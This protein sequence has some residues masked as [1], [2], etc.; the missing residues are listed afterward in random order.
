MQ[1]TVSA[2]VIAANVR[3][4]LEEDI[5]TGD[6]T[7]ML[8]P[9]EQ[10]AK[11]QVITREDATICGVD[12]VNEVF[13]QVD[14]KLEIHWQVKD[15]EQVV[16]NQ[17]LFTCQGPARSLLTAERSALNFLQML[18]GTATSCRQYANQ[19]DGSN[20]KLLD[21]RKTIPGLREAQK[22]AVTCGG[23]HNHRM[24][25][26]DAFLI[27]ENHIMACGGIEQAVLKARE[28]APDK[29][30]E[31][32]VEDLNQLQ[33]AIDAKADVVMLDNFS[34]EDLQAAV[35]INAG[36]AYLE[37]SGNIELESLSKLTNSNVDFISSGALTKAVIP[38]D[39]SLRIN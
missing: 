19:L 37:V 1:T 23:C 22:Y 34:S 4:A 36:K 11:A 8:I 17:V 33:Q 27:K 20:I 32:E 9:L 6:I 24:G 12:W 7:A 31:V 39:L 28:I 29:K 16:A 26:Y 2:H 38:I 14:P 13:N 3:A 21:T 5:G 10:Q 18:S 15:G 25:L 30:V 35:S